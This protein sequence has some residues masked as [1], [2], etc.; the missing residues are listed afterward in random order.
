MPDVDLALALVVLVVLGALLA[1]TVLTS[2]PSAAWA[3]AVVSACW[4]PA[5][6]S[7]EGPSI[8]VISPGHGV[9]VADTVALVGFAAAT[10][11]L[12]FNRPRTSRRLS[13]VGAHAGSLGVAAALPV[14]M[15]LWII[16]L[17]GAL[18]AYTQRS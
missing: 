5:D 13:S 7:V 12:V 6:S 10:C 17:V 18:A 11:R 16:G 14:V 9:T 8:V 4:L 15:V 3:L 1:S 2:T